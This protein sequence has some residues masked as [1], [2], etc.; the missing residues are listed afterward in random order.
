MTTARRYGT[1]GLPCPECGG[2][3]QVYDSR[4]VSTNDGIKRY[5][6]CQSCGL[7]FQTLE[8]YNGKE[9]KPQAGFTYRLQV[10]QSVAQSE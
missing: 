7:R 4:P 6:E 9:R 8:T 5:R 2:D 1:R 3:T 10:P